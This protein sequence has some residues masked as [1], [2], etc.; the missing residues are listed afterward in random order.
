MRAAGVS[1][2][3]AVAALAMIRPNILHGAERKRGHRG[4]P[5]MLP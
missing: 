5:A 2:A 4:R 3:V 1:G